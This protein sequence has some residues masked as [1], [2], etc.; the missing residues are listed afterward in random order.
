[1]TELKKISGVCENHV[2]CTTVAIESLGVVH[3]AHS[4][5]AKRL[6]I[7]VK[8]DRSIRVAI[9]KGVARAT[10]EQ[11]L[12]IKIPWI[13]KSLVK[14][15]KLQKKKSPQ[16]DIRDIDRGKA[17]AY[18]T[19]RI[20]RLANEYGFEF[21]KLFI[22]NQKT[23]WGSCSSKD[24]ISL[25]MKLLFLPVELQDY[26]I[27]HELVHTKHKNHG[28]KFWKAMDKLVGDARGLRNQMRQYSL[29]KLIW[30]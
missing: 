26:V 21:N 29:K 13:K 15:Q 27:L 18:L 12:R 14:I 16:Y 3:F 22:R 28:K 2:N 24:N 23:R 10:A 25:N 8:H 6:S 4:A 9:P 17:K 19:M 7:T 30:L 20:N 1:M 5:R 11:F